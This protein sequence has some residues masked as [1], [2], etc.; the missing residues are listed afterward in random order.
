MEN[1]TWTYSYKQSELENLESAVRYCQCVLLF[2]SL[3]IWKCLHFILELKKPTKKHTKTI[4]W[5]VNQSSSTQL[6]R[7]TLFSHSIQQ[8]VST[9]NF[10]SIRDCKVPYN[11]HIFE[12]SYERNRCTFSAF[13]SIKRV[14]FWLSAISITSLRPFPNCER[15]VFFIARVKAK[16]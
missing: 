8:V 10:N 4:K 7:V 1:N 15:L 11:K 14:I 9:S 6:R 13:T 2:N 5:Q 12:M 3:K 16:T